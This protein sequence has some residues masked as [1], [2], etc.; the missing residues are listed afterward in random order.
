MTVRGAL[1]GGP[2]VMLGAVTALVLVYAFDWDDPVSV[3]LLGAA[4]AGAAASAAAP[5]QDAAGR[6]AALAGGAG[7]GATAGLAALAGG[8]CWGGCGG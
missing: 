2:P 4:V 7:L 1:R 3:A 6:A 5:P 8:F